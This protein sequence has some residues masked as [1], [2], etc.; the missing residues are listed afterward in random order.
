MHHPTDKIIHTT[1]TSRGALVRMSNSSMGPP[2]EGPILRPI[3]PSNALTMELL[4]LALDA[5]REGEGE[6]GW[7]GGGGERVRWKESVCE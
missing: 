7:G 4:H 2:H 1:D 3:A 5:Y 6:G